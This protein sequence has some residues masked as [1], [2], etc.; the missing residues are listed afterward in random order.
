MQFSG[1]DLCSVSASGPGTYTMKK[2]ER[3]KSSG[4]AAT[5]A[6]KSTSNSNYQKK[7]SASTMV[8][9]TGTDS[10]TPEVDGLPVHR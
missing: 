2:V 9:G 3:P 8:S 6:N 7:P 1:A 5:A 4:S 10:T